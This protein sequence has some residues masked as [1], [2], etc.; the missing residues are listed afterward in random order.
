MLAKLSR[1]SFL[2]SWQ[3]SCPHIKNRVLLKSFRPYPKSARLS[4]ARPR[5]RDED[6]TD[7]L[8]FNL[9]V[10]YEITST[11]FVLFVGSGIILVILQKNIFKVREVLLQQTVEDIP[12]R[13]ASSKNIR[14]RLK[15][16]KT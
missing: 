7:I 13:F 3:G 1:T 15:K 10:V 11:V 5:L 4:R 2:K 9:T 6:T 16:T 12:Q 14:A 8:K